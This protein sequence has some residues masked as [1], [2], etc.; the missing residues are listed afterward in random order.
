MPLY[1]QLVTVLDIFPANDTHV[2][3]GYISGYPTLLSSQTN[4]RTIN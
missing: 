4:W 3:V 2:D 1:L